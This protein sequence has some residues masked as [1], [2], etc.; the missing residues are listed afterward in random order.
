MNNDLSGAMKGFLPNE[1]QSIIWF[2][3]VSHKSVFLSDVQ[4]GVLS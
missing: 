2:I 1:S 4:E 3:C